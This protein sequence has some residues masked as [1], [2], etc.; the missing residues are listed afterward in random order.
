[1][2]PDL[3]DILARIVA[4]KRLEVAEKLKLRKGLERIAEAQRSQRRPFRQALEAVTP[5]IIAEIKQASPSK[6]LLCADFNPARHAMEYFAGRA[7][8][9]SILTD[10]EFFQ[11]SLGD[12]K[13]ARA[14]A[15]LPVLRKDFTIDEIDVIESAAAGADAILLIAAL[16]TGAQME[17]FQSLADYY[18]MEALVEV[19]D[20]PELE[21]ALAAGARIIGI[22]NR[23]LRTFA[24]S[25]ETA[26]QLAPLIPA[27]VLKVA[28]SGIHSRAD[29]ERLVAC[30]FQA[31]LVGEHLMTSSDVGAAL[32]ALT[33]R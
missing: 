21:R 3:P 15:A 28:E 1:M 19:H 25:L 13:T 9:L 18:G 12:L 22:N 26:E 4:V 23:D 16:L 14:C 10:K 32:R 17:R 31:F 11:G 8:A 29:V 2:P 5:A 27:T 7:S 24:V 20:Q 30:G 33:G 6:G